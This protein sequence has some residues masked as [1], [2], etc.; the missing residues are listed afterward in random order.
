MASFFKRH[1]SDP[2]APSTISWTA[3]FFFL[4][5]IIALI[6]IILWSFLG[7]ITVNVIGKGVIV[8][9]SGLASLQSKLAG[10]V[11]GI[12]VKLMILSKKG[13]Y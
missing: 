1:T 3:W 11:L 6:L 2:P 13:N 10:E 12:F 4:L 7:S 8:P 9:E 5:S